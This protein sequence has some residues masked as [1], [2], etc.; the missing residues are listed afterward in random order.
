MRKTTSHTQRKHRGLEYRILEAVCESYDVAIPDELKKRRGKLNEARNVAIYLT[1]KIRWDTV[2]EI[3]YYFQID[4]I[5]TMSS[6]MNVGK[7]SWSGI[8]SCASVRIN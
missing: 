1:R 5:N 4:N 6:V 3:G 8:V 2:K 7:R